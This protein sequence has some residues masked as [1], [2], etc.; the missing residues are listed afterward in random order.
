[1][2]MKVPAVA[3]I[4]AAGFIGGCSGV[5]HNA[6]STSQVISSFDGVASRDASN[7]KLKII[8]VYHLPRGTQPSGIV[9]GSDGNLWF[10]LAG[11]L[12]IGRITP[13]GHVTYFPASKRDFGVRI[14][15]GPDKNL[16]FT[17]FGFP[18]IDRMTTSGTFTAFVVQGN[19]QDI[20]SGPDGALWYTDFTL[21]SIGRMTLQ[22]KFKEY[23][24]PTPQSYPYDITV[25]PDKNLW[26]D[27]QNSGK[28]GKITTAGAITEY[29]IS[30]SNPIPVGIA[31]AHGNI[32]AAENRFPKIA[33][34]TPAG[35]VTTYQSPQA[36]N[37]LDLIN[38]G[39]GRL[40]VSARY[41]GKI[42]MFDPVTHTFSSFVDVPKRAG[43]TN[44][45]P[46]GI[47]LGPDG[48]IWFTS[49]NDDYIGVADDTP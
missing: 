46:D 42:G 19:P 7:P 1:M 3:L 30:D 34:I 23:T 27:E 12:T 4:A 33:Q 32:Y 14:T 16:W 2:K 18:E 8:A 43:E 11:H 28:V 21:Q 15:R 44:A 48:D 20:V 36:L 31:S 22:G 35:V 40:I 26:F 38:D 45:G 9:M 5:G 37:F 39:H 49:V 47:A 17:V 10:T 25:G 6:L 24:V 41:Q 13:T 29:T